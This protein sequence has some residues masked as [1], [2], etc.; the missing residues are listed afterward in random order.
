MNQQLHH[1][2]LII[3]CVETCYAAFYALNFIEIFQRAIK[4]HF[5]QV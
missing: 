5:Q 1:G 2:R 3:C 4:G